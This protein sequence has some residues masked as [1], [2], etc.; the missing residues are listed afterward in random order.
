MSGERILVADDSREVRDFLADYI[1]RPAGFNVTIVEDGTA[2]LH[3]AREQ[4]PDLIIADLNMPGLTGLQ[5]KKAL[6][7]DGNAIPFILM[8]A[9]GSEQIITE[10]VMAG[11]V[12][13]LPKPVDGDVMLAAVEQALETQRARRQQAAYEKRVRDLETLQKIGR[14]LTTTLDLDNVLSQVV[15]A[16]VSLTGAEEG[17]LLLLDEGTGELIMRAAR[18]FDDQFV[19]TFR[20]RSDDSLAGQVIQT[21]QP[22]LLGADS[23]KKIKT[24]YLVRSLIYI[25]LRLRE[26]IIGVLGVDNRAGGRMFNEA[27]LAPLTILADYAAIAIE[28]ARL[29]ARADTER[30]KLDAILQNT[31]DGVIVVDGSARLVMI[32]GAA[33]KALNLSTAE[34]DGLPLPEVIR[35]A[36]LLSL[37]AQLTTGG[38]N[39]RTEV[40]TEDGRVFNA[41][42]T[43]ISAVGH[44]VVMQDITHLKQLDRIKSEFVTTVSHDLRSP[45][46]TIMGYLELLKRV[47]PMSDQQMEFVDR[48]NMSVNAITTLITDLLDLGRIEAGFDSQKEPLSLPL[49]VRYAIEGLTA[50]AEDKKLNIVTQLPEKAPQVFGNPIRL[51]QMAANL[52]ENAIKY[53]PENGTI[54]VAVLEADDHELLSITDTGIGIPLADQPYVFDKF[55][56]SKNVPEEVVGT[57]LGLSIVKSIVENHGGRIWVDSTPGQGATFTVVLPKYDQIKATVLQTRS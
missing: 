38:F 45:L 28:N 12:R 55:Y 43:P 16:A 42:L 36:D 19:R 54:T 4:R 26:Q 13:Y 7:A 44:V 22:I 47:G 2:A 21:G 53:T 29:Y 9:E 57:G 30:A 3:A 56:R 10:S 50:K 25:P 24:A 5:L 41:Q 14:A 8:T 20:L 46:T 1:L 40:T 39:R 18:N 51:R 27:D 33:R 37:F 11:I 31:E 52:V 15:E 35:N 48:I 23:P 34:V 49:V 17:S 32:N 6:S